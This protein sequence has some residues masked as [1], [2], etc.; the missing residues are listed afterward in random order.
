MYFLLDLTL[1]IYCG[2]RNT[3]SLS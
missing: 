1:F 3:S 2:K